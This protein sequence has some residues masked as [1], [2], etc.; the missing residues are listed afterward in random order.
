MPPEQ[1]RAKELDARSDLSSFGA[2]LYEMPTAVLAIVAMLVVGLSAGTAW[3]VLR[4]RPENRA[5][6][7]VRDDAARRVLAVLPLD[8]ISND[9]S[10]DYFSAGMT[11]EINGQ[12][13]K[14]AS[15]QVLSRTAVARYKDPKS[16]LRQI[17][18]E[19]G[20]GSVVLGSV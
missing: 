7:A 4:T 17:A 20:V 19:L 16:N 11:E 9:R 8:N 14:V 12:L 1:V 2:V 18:T 15:L 6:S 13:S 5:G 10:Q 3:W